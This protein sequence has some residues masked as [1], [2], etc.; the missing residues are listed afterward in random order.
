V[1]R[2]QFLDFSIQFG[3]AASL[4]ST[5]FLVHLLD[6][7]VQKAVLYFSMVASASSLVAI[8]L[9]VRAAGFEINLTNIFRLRSGMCS[10]RGIVR[11]HI[12]GVVT[13]E[14]N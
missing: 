12:P 5:L 7:P 3:F 1:I 14:K 11:V 8:F 6:M 9:V 10:K 2:K 4:L 13:E